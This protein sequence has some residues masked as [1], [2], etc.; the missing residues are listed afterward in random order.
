ML[1]GTSV[2]LATR[3][4]YL[5]IYVLGP[6]L[7]YLIV[8]HTNSMKASTKKSYTILIL[9]CLSLAVFAHLSEDVDT[10]IL[11]KD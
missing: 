8:G 3:I 9:R 7:R 1:C 5:A 2:A 11:D 10:T 4:F 6:N